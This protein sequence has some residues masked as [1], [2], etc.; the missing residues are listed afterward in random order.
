[1]R[2]SYG[3]EAQEQALRQ[4]VEYDPVELRTVKQERMPELAF[5]SPVPGTL[6][7]GVLSFVCKYQIKDRRAGNPG[8]GFL[9]TTG[10]GLQDLMP[11]VRQFFEWKPQ[12]ASTDCPER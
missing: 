2:Y 9:R 10:T 11:L 5:E 8:G 3:C 12:D 4:W 7:E 6:P 1:M